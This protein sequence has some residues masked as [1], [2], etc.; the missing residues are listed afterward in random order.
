MH[1][2]AEQSI[3]APVG[4]I[5]VYHYAHQLPVQDVHQEIAAHNEVELVPIVRLDQRLE[6]VL[7]S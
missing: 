1:L 7:I 2:H 4:C 6:L 3:R 5:I